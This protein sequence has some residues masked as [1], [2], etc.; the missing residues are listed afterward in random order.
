MRSFVAVV[1]FLTCGLA[2]STIRYHV[3]LGGLSDED[4]NPQFN[5]EHYASANIFLV[6]GLIL[7]IIG[8]CLNVNS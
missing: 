4:L 6:I 3:T 7:P 5:Y 2:I 1:C 8:Y